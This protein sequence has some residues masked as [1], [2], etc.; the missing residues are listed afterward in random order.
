MI[1]FAEIFLA[2]KGS[3]P[4]PWAAAILGVLLLRRAITPAKQSAL[5]IVA[6]CLLVTLLV[7]ADHGFLNVNRLAWIG[8]L[9]VV[10][11]GY[12]FGE[13]IEKLW[14]SGPRT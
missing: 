11:F 5:A 7:A 2:P 9:V 3:D 4:G 13:R 12:A 10:G 1:S 8:V 6:G 14:T